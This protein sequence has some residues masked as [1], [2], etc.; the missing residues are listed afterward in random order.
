[1]VTSEFSA[2]L[3]INKTHKVTE[4]QFLPNYKNK[5]TKV[6]GFIATQ[7]SSAALLGK[8]FD[9]PIVSR[10]LGILNGSWVADKW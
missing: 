8:M 4:H 6:Y 10:H 9:H 2:V 7:L 3:R 5:V 1:M